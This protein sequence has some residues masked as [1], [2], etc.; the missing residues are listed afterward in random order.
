MSSSFALRTL[1]PLPLSFPSLVSRAAKG[2]GRDSRVV[3]VGETK[4]RCFSISFFFSFFCSSSTSSLS[5]SSLPFLRSLPL[6]DHSLVIP[7]SEC[8]DLNGSLPFYSNS[9]V[10][11]SPFELYT[12]RNWTGVSRWETDWKA[13]VSLAC[14]ILKKNSRR[15]EVVR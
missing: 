12:V 5:I 14:V 6:F 13:G 9:P 11:T 10:A 4:A 2:R 15:I 8:F 3:V 7:S 1:P